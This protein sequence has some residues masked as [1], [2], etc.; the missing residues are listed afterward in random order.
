MKISSICNY[1][2]QYTDY[3]NCIDFFQASSLG[4]QKGYGKIYAGL[5]SVMQFLDC[6]EAGPRKF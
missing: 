2:V 5:D 1:E 3:A 4:G 6:P